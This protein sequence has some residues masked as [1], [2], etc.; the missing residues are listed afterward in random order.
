MKIYQIHKE[1]GEYEDFTVEVMGT[2]LNSDKANHD[3]Q[4]M[5]KEFEIIE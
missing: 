2:Y 3:M 4:E 1:S 5:E